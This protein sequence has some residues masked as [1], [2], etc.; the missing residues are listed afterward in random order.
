MT[1]PNEKSKPFDRTL[2]EGPILKALWKLAWPTMLQNIIA[3]LQGIVDHTLVGHLVGR[4]ANAA[5]G[6]SWQIF[7]VVVVFTS[8]LFSGMGVLVARFAGAD[9]AEKVNR[10]IYQAFLTAVILACFILA[11]LGYFFAPQLLDLV[12]AAPEVKAEA[13]PYIRIMFVFSF[14][15]LIFFMLGG[16]LR[17][18]GDAKTP[19]RLG[20]ILTVLNLALNLVLI[21]GLGPIPQFGTRGSAMG[22]T[23]AAGFVALIGLYLLFSQKLVVQFSKKMSWKPDWQIIGALFKFGLPTGFQGIAMNVGGVIMLRFIGSLQQSAA[24]HAAYAVSYTQLFSLITWTS[25]GLMGATVAMVGQNLGAGKPERAVLAA[26]TASRIGLTLAT[27]IGL[28]F[29]FIPQQ[30]LAIFGMKD[31][32]TVDLGTGLLRFLSLS[33]LFVTV[34]LVYNGALQG[35]GDTRSPLFI[36]LISQFVLPIGLCSALQSLRP[37]QPN[38]VWLAIVLGHATRALFSFWRFRQEKWKKIKVEIGA[39]TA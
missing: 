23:I 19:L 11:P 39:A 22:T 20:V 21:S 28:L 2:T 16:A 32:I 26:H 34:A 18:A 35:T 29:M 3:G 33:G 25:V 4:N 15:M 12:H 37:L 1:T 10:V 30:L 7:L 24:A 17:A 9:D 8:S 38:D 27:V 5:I 13:L 6:V 36:T 31:P 14:G